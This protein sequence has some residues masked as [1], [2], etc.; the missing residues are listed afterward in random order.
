MNAIFL[1]PFE[2]PANA[3]IS[4]LVK[5]GNQPV[6]SP[7]GIDT[8]STLLKV[9]LSEGTPLRNAA[10][11]EITRVKTTIFKKLNSQIP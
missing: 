6:N 10:V 7:L 5:L 1:Q 3:V 8:M 2:V 4:Q 11:S 9:A